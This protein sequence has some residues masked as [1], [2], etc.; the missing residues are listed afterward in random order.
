MFC[1]ITAILAIPLMLAAVV[2]VAAQDSDFSRSAPPNHLA[3]GNL[4]NPDIAPPQALYRGRTY[5]E[6]SAAWFQWAYSMPST[7]HPLYDTAP[8]GAGQTGNVWFLDATHGTPFPTQGRDCTIPA[9]TALFLNIAASYVD[10]EGC[11][12]TGD[13]IQRTA[14]AESELA[15]TASNNLTGFLGTRGVAIDGVNVMGLPVCDPSNPV[16]CESPYRVPSP[17]F[18]MTV[19]AANNLL[20]QDDGPCYSTLATPYTDIGAVADGLYVMIKPLRVGQHT[21]R[22]GRVDQGLPRLYNITVRP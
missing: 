14:L 16:S 6:W 10:N 13:T 21:I 17:V 20:I 11:S 7:A 12:K 5:G 2:P 9:G 22:F 18:N 8:C 3:V 15:L 4:G 19:P 1:P